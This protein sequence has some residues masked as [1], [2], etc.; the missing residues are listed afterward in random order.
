MPLTINAELAAVLVAAAAT[1]G[2]IQLPSRGDVLALR[3]FIDRNL[4]AVDSAEPDS[5]NVSSQDHQIEVAGG[6]SI[7]A[8][9]YTKA[10]SNPGSAVVY[11]HGGGMV[12]GSV[13]IYDKSVA[14][15][16]EETGVP[17]L[18]VDYRL[19]PEFTGT[20]LVDDGHSALEW[21]VGQAEVLQVDPRRIAVLGDSGGGGVAAGVAIAARNAGTPLAK[22]ILIY[23][24]LDD[25]NLDP[26][27]EIAPF[28][29]W[30]YDN[31]YTGWHALLGENLGTDRV[32]P[33]A[34]PA[35]LSDFAGLAPA[36][37]DVGELDIF[38][39][40]NIR[41]ALNLFR[42]GVSC[43][44]Y[45]RPGSMH[46]FDRLAPTSR[47]ASASWDDRYHAITSL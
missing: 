6:A 33:L 3:E 47:V 9:W 32:S 15:Y 23:P 11:F 5:Q 13:G 24:M 37:I 38:R 27:P 41:Y 26:D 8:R 40:E 35:R 21:L 14:R 46:G 2:Q 43:E 34:A 31:N 42:A 10:G 30:T 18:S 7:L 36:F 39:D 12:G 45:V 29:G 4:A 19:A 25:R 1:S 20:S 28:A 17:F 16:V 44:L 22:Q